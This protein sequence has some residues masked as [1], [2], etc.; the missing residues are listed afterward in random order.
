ML[1]QVSSVLF[2]DASSATRISDGVTAAYRGYATGFHRA[3]HSVGIGTQGERCQNRVGDTLGSNGLG[4]VG[5]ESR[6]EDFLA[7]GHGGHGHDRDR[8]H[9]LRAA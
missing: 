9:A 8:S 2:R 3:N 5:V 6:V 1:G 4:H 7:A